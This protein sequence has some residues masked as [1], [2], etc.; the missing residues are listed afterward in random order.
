MQSKFL[1]WKT[2]RSFFLC[3][4]TLGRGLV[5]TLVQFLMFFDLKT[6]LHSR[7]FSRSILN[8]MISKMN[9]YLSPLYTWSNYALFCFLM[10]LKSLLS[11]I[12][13]KDFVV[14]YMFYE[15]L[16]ILRNTHYISNPDNFV[17]IS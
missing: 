8:S 9:S 7:I 6:L 13:P 14:G 1:L 2:R 15:I 12:L 17:Y 10:I 3:W 16:S 5:P 11:Y 4:A